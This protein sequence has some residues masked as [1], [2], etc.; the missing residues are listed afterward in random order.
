MT[1]VTAGKGSAQ[2][3]LPIR[4]HDLLLVLAGRLDDDALAEARELVAA[5]EVDRALEFVVG[6]L[7]AGPIALTQDE[8]AE[9]HDLMV[10]AHCD[11][12]VAARVPVSETA[13]ALRHRFV[14]GR[15]DG[16]SPEDGV[17]EAAARVL[18]VLPDIRAV[19]AV[20]RT[21]PAGAVSGPVPHRVV[22]IGVGPGGF[23]PATAYRVQHALRRAGLTASVE[24]LR[25]G[26]DHSDY[27]HAAVRYATE[28]MA[29]R[30]SLPPATGSPAPAQPAAAP[31]APPQPDPE[32][33]SGPSWMEE[34]PQTG[35][36]DSL[37]DN[38][39]DLLRQLQEEL[40]R[41]EQADGAAPQPGW[42]GDLSGGNHPFDWHEAN[43]MVNGVPL[44]PPDQRS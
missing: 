41:R 10:A 3:A 19:W 43:T 21:T 9:L 6:C 16:V 33:V 8:Q 25:E 37:N 7:V 17:A 4:V 29:E 34:A 40:A 28:V 1:Q 2:T 18:D 27:H 12:T 42:Q 5:T 15:V 11:P 24:V 39:L 36:S 35:P 23:A 13:A 38:E 22:L 31:A 20:W 30:A 32:P 14:A 26:A 44:Q